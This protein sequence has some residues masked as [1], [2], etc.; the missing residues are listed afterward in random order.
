MTQQSFRSI[1]IPFKEKQKLITRMN[2]YVWNTTTIIVV[3][4]IYFSCAIGTCTCVDRDIAS[5]RWL[6][7]TATN[8][9][10]AVVTAL[11]TKEE[12]FHVDVPSLHHRE[13]A[14]TLQIVVGQVG[15]PIEKL[16]KCQGDCDGSTECQDGLICM[17]RS[18]NEPVP[19]CLG[20]TSSKYGI[21]FCID[22]NDTIMNPTKEGALADD[23]PG[24]SVPTRAPT[25]QHKTKTATTTTTTTTSALSGHCRQEQL[26]FSTCLS[27]KAVC[28]QCF[29]P[30]LGQQ[31]SC[32][33]LE[34][35]VCN[36][37]NT[38]ACE[39]DRCA[40]VFKSYYDCVS[41]NVCSALQCDGT[42]GIVLQ[43]P[44]T[45]APAVLDKN[46]NNN[47]MKSSPPTPSPVPL[48]NYKGSTVL[49]DVG[50]NEQQ[51]GISLGRCEGDW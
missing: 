13:L 11:V 17:Q 7:S 8:S 9:R 14:N 18:A 39:C 41:D 35:S 50:N 43:M 38:D 3:S 47:D 6:R 49:K 42:A 12:Q 36:V 23:D 24:T 16:A 5:N 51:D 31:S 15:T 25:K 32:D 48:H 21:D 27:G 34:E 28:R 30:I 19:G 33:S 4:V 40:R 1:I 37:L 2:C 20:L 10:S 22:P 44:T 46:D 26:D 45:P 29:A